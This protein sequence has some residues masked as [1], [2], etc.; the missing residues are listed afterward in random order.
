VAKV[1]LNLVVLRCPDLARAQTF[2]SALG[3]PLQREQHGKGPEHLAAELG[4]AVFEIYPL[5]D[6]ESTLGV[7]VGF[8][9]PKVADAVAA[10]L[11]NGGTL[12]TPPRN[13]PW[14]LRAVVADP[15]GHRVELVD[16]AA[17]VTVPP[18]PT[19]TVEFIDSMIDE[20]ISRPRD[21]K[22]TPDELEAMLWAYEDVRNQIVRQ[23][24][25]SQVHNDYVS[26]LMTTECQT[27]TY[28]IRQRLENRV[29]T[30]EGLCDLW[31]E[32]I[33]WRVWRNSLPLSEQRFPQRRPPG[34]A[35]E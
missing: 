2:Y 5:G 10:A 20:V 6:S 18:L 12:I 23:K 14:G 34:D 13:G 35:D 33:A 25:S 24:D 17:K 16:E 9:V 3:L 27:A 11:S 15:D 28:C 21:F 1:E 31:R 30:M 4:E 7:R 32:F 19:D 22:D 8:R 29:P 26:F